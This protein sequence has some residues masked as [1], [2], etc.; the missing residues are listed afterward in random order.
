MN[1]IDWKR[2]KAASGSLVEFIKTYCVGLMVDDAPSAKF[3]DALREM[4]FALNQS[5]PYN[6]ELPRGQGKT[7]AV[8]MAVLYLLATGKRKFCVIVSQNARAASNI[9]RDIWRPIVEKDTAFSQDFPE[10]CLPFQLCDGSYRRR[11][12]HM[13]VSTEI[14][15][16]A[17]VI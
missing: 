10:V 6:I 13:G 5:R 1:E 4:E 9:L 8:E 3:V 11:Q 15:K 17:A 16:N 7:S 14:Q 12:L 2:R